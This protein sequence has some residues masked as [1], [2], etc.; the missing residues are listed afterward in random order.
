MSLN[1]TFGDFFTS[2]VKIQTQIY[3][4]DF[5]RQGWLSSCGAWAIDARQ[6]VDADDEVQIKWFVTHRPTKH[7]AVDFPSAMQAVMY[8]EKMNARGD[9]SK[10]FETIP[11]YGTYFRSTDPLYA[12]M[13][14]AHRQVT[15]EMAAESTSPAEGGATQKENE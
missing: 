12:A 2:V 3:G 6:I 1:W 7:R 8:C 13:A 10:G 5:R 4:D 11:S 15:A 9:F 14:N